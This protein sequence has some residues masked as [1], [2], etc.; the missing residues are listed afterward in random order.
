MNI[1]LIIIFICFLIPLYG[2]GQSIESSNIILAR[3]DSSEM[4]FYQYH[5]PLKIMAGYTNIIEATNE[6]PEQLVQSVLS[7]RNQKWVNYNT[8]G[9]AENASQKNQAHFDRVI[10]MDKEQNYFELH[11]KVSFDIGGISTSFVKFFFYQEGEKPVSGCMVMQKI[12]DQW[13]KTSHPSFSLLSIIL[14]RL[15]SDVLE[16]IVLGNS[17]VPQVNEL[18]ERVTSNGSLD[19]QKFED[20]F[21]SWYRPVI[22]QQKISLYKDPQTW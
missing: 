3:V 18:R 2:F 14:M 10:S 21:A 5:P 19:L 16:G 12:G 15:K 13:Y 7:A 4:N 22:D 1:R 9:G 8:L 17:N 11:H 20:E 6:Y